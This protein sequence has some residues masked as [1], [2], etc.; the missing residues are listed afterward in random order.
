[1]FILLA[2]SWRESNYGN[3]GLGWPNSTACIDEV[4]DGLRAGNPTDGAPA[5]SIEDHLDGARQGL[6]ALDRQRMDT[7]RMCDK[8]QKRGVRKPPH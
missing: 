2:N 5:A 4:R 6:L 1:V 8:M 3:I 7:D